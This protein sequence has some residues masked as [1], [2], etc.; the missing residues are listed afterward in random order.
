MKINKKIVAIFTVIFIIAVVINVIPSKGSEKKTLSVFSDISRGN[1][2]LAVQ[3]TLNKNDIMMNYSGNWRDVSDIKLKYSSVITDEEKSI[4]N[5]Y[6]LKEEELYSVSKKGT[7]RKLNYDDIDK[8]LSN[9]YDKFSND[10]ILF[11]PNTY[12]WFNNYDKSNKPY[13]YDSVG[14]II[15]EDETII[16]ILYDSEIDS[17]KDYDVNVIY[18]KQG[19]SIRDNLSILVKKN[20]IKSNKEKQIIDELK[21]EIDNLRGESNGY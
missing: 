19:K 21:R 16:G 10:I 8:Y 5:I 17:I 6:T 20:L 7:G 3:D 13:I 11:T 9:S 15:K 12:K 2:N 18:D 4:Y 1:I 14:K